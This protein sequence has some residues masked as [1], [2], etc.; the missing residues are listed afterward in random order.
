[1][2]VSR[3]PWGDRGLAI[4]AHVTEGAFIIDILWQLPETSRAK[5]RFAHNFWHIVLK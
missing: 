4:E 1:M 3:F 2:R 5:F